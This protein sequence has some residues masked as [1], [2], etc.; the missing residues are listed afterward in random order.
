M[1]GQ[2]IRAQILANLR[3]NAQQ[4]TNGTRKP[5]VEKPVRTV[6]LYM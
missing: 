4:K 6:T 3:N 2:N 5:Q 1:N